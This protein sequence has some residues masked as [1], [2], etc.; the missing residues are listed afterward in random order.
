M[1]LNLTLVL[2]DGLLKL[3]VLLVKLV[4]VVEELHIL[5]LCFDECC[6]DFIDVVDACCLHDGLKGLLNNL[7]IA[8]VLIK[9]TLLFYILVNHRVDTDLQNFNRV[10]ELLSPTLSLLRLHCTTQ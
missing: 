8:D 1:V 2:P 10:R 5:F 3:V 6:H 4:D 7:S 9:Q